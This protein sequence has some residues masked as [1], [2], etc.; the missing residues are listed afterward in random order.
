[1]NKCDENKYQPNYKTGKRKND[2]AHLVQFSRNVLAVPVS[3]IVF[4]KNKEKEKP[5]QYTN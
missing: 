1:M 2:S 3:H 5:L 4:E